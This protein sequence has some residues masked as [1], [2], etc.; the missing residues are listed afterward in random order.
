MIRTLINKIGPS[1]TPAAAITSPPRRL[2][3]LAS[4][5]ILALA[6]CTAGGCASTSQ[7]GGKDLSAAGV[8]TANGLADF[9]D[10]LAGYCIDTAELDTLN[11]GFQALLN[12]PEGRAA[13]AR[14]HEAYESLAQAFNRR[15]AMARGLA[16]LYASVG[17]LAA[18][19]A[20]GKV[21]AAA[22]DLSGAV[23]DLPALT[24]KLDFDPKAI[25]TMIAGDLIALKQSA[26]I[27]TASQA[28]AKVLDGVADLLDAE[29]GGASGK[30]DVYHSIILRRAELSG[31][32]TKNLVKSG[33]VDSTAVMKT[34]ADQYQI[35]WDGQIKPD[36]AATRAA[37]ANIAAFQTR[38]DGAL[39][40]AAADDLARALR[41]LAAQHRQFAQGG[42]FNPADANALAQRA[43]AYI[44]EVEKI[45]KEARDTRAA[46]RE[47]EK[48]DKD[49]NK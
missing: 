43:Q 38:R 10:Q 1:R 11:F 20:R 19:D 25:T 33:Y 49:K 35:P 32:L 18:V 26:D 5:L 4:L 27:R 36:D 8:K 13:D 24:G 40:L 28:T 41:A 22:G 31:S 42:P 39:S 44:D 46:R 30:N 47:Q 29:R 48:T 21:G 14:N 3:R 15:A 6:L 12:D 2:S 34:I 17:N 16:A 23:T 37:A 9:Y 45:K 7:Q